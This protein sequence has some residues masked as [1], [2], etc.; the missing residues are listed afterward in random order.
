LDR[1]KCLRKIELFPY[2]P[3]MQCE[4]H[5]GL[6]YRECCGE[7]HSGKQLPESALVLMRARFSAYARHLTDF[8][9]QTTHPDNPWFVED[10]KKW[11]ESIDRFCKG[12]E[13][14]GLKIHEFV[15]G[16]QKAFVTFYAHLIQRGKDVSFTE[17][18]HFIKIDDQWLYLSG[19]IEE[20]HAKKPL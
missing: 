1:F 12:T 8:I 10:Q 4:C 20:H 9:I 13:F 14:R 17:C 18:S 19:T 5:S 6:P 3:Y 2:I 16:E 7:Y 11:H 15:E